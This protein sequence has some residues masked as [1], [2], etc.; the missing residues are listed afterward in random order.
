[1]AMGLD[2]GV[3]GPDEQS[4]NL[5]VLQPAVRKKRRHEVAGETDGSG[6]NVFWFPAHS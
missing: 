2:G 6:D 5:D 3:T 4:V 1:M